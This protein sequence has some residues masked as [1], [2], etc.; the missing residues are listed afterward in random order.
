MDEHRLNDPIAA[1]AAA[2]GETH[3]ERVWFELSVLRRQG[4][5]IDVDVH[6]VTMFSRRA[7]MT[8]LGIPRSSVRGRTCTAGQTY[9]IPREVHGRLQSISRRMRGVLDKYAH[10]VAGFRPYRYLYYAA[11][12]A[13]V[14][15]WN[16]LAAEWD[17]LKETILAHL[18]EWREAYLAAEA[19]RAAEAWDAILAANGHAN[20][21]ADDGRLVLNL[22]GGALTFDSRDEFIAWMVDRAR[23]LFP[24]R[25]DVESNLTAEYKTAVLMTAADLE[26]ESERAAALRRQAAEH[27][28]AE[29]EAYERARLA[30]SEAEIK[31]EAIRQAELEHAREQ[32]QHIASPFEELF[33]NL[34]AWAYA[35]AT[36]IAASVD[37]NG[38]LNPKVAERVN[39][40]LEMFKMKDAVGDDDL[41]RQLEVLRERAAATPRQTGR[42]GSV[43]P[44]DA[45]A[46]TDL[47]AALQD[48]LTTTREAAD[49]AAARAA[50]AGT[51]R[52]GGLVRKVL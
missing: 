39:S 16:E 50:R 6:G 20:G 19:A 47:R 18:D 34:R 25:S 14:A 29:V 49:R 13:F 31:M 9:L 43:A 52:A 45:V 3:F 38:F 7:T 48:V 51:L 35:E 4:I 21:H 1:A 42:P 26:A 37:K 2:T 24:S 28:A 23:P 17:E 22:R 10:D 11:Y 12:D 5:L 40:L 44:A 32:L 36:E 30:R 15:R 8:G 41:R 46:L 33:T 27:H